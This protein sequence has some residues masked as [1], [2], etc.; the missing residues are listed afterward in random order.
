MR[1]WLAVCALAL[2]GL[3]PLQSLAQ[4]CA[5]PG[6]SGALTVTGTNTVINAYYPGV[7][8]SL[9][10]A[11]S[12]G[13]DSS[14]G[15]GAGTIAAGDMVLI[16]QMQDG[17]GATLAQDATY[18]FPATRAGDYEIA[19]VVSVGANVLNLSAGL[20]NP[21]TQNLANNLTYQV[22]RVPQYS[23][24]TINGG[25]S[26]VPV[27]WDG[28]T[29]GVVMA[30]VSGAFINNGSIDASYAGFRGNAGQSLGGVAGAAANTTANF[31]R[32]QPDGYAA[33]GGKGEGTA[34]TPD[35]VANVFASPGTL[36][37][38]ANGAATNST[39]AASSIAGNA[40]YL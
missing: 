30:D 10:A 2:A 9:A 34:G 38:L 32:Y 13:Y 16:I 24:L 12:I 6:V 5:A 31:T 22:I 11:T 25:A 8:A 29:G 35:R 40:A 19:R 33:H 23:T 27:P 17:A 18:N 15:R 7:G 21:Y 36:L 14:L 39:A 1:Q 37:A 26:V 20:I 28:T 3:L 4:V